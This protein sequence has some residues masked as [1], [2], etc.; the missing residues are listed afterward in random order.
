MNSKIQKI[1]SQLQL[2]GFI[3]ETIV[4]YCNKIGKE[5]L[6]FYNTQYDFISIWRRTKD[7]IATEIIIFEKN[8]Q[9][10][11]KINSSTLL[12]QNTTF[13]LNNC[14][15]PEVLLHSY[16]FNNEELLKQKIK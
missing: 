6:E 15:F 2:K 5:L 12:Q 16:L 3:E 11:I 7:N 4:E 10:L 1:I 9:I 13:S 8:E 14:E